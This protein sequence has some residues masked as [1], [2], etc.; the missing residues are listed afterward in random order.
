MK[1]LFETTYKIIQEAHEAYKKAGNDEEGKQVAR[2]NVQVALEKIQA[3]GVEVWRLWQCY[4][5]ARDR[6]N[7]HLD[8]NEVVWDKDV[9]PLIEAMRTYGIEAFTF[10]SGWS[11]AVETAWLFKENGCT[12][13]ALV[14]INGISDK[15]H[16]YLFKVN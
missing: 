7:E 11:S 15:K 2:N 5:T 16:G 13:E 6:G 1:E 10:S 9:K 12:L 4:E 8:I 14:E 3:C